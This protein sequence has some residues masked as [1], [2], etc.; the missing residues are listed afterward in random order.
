[1]RAGIAP[2]TPDQLAAIF[3]RREHRYGPIEALG[4][5]ATQTWRATST[6][7]TSL[8][9]VFTGRDA[10][11][12]NLGGP[13]KVA[14]VVREEAAAGGAA[15][16]WGIVAMLSITLAV[17]NILPIP[18]LDGGH[19]LFLIYEGIVRREPS[20]KVRIALQQVGMVVLLLFMVFLFVNDALS[21]F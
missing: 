10:F 18:A 8:T 4:A 15:A 16:F 3:G 2:P 17:M 20:L 21:L 5:G 6:V 1:F 9:R 7:V 14:K 12:E 19:L 11:R 13:L